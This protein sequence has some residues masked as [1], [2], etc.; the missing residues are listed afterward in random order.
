LAE[1][2]VRMGEMKNAYKI[3]VGKN[4]WK[5]P[6]VRPKHRWEENIRIDLREIRWEYVDWIQLT[7]NRGQWWA[8]LSGSI[9][10]GE[11]LD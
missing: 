6:R 7:Q 5:R 3:L 2:A 4:A 1:H 11:F 10:D 8:F 9:K